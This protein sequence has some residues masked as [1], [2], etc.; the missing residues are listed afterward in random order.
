M[1]TWPVEWRVPV[2]HDM[3]P[4]TVVC[5]RHT[6]L[7]AMYR[8]FLIEAS[9]SPPLCFLD[10]AKERTAEIVRLVSMLAVR[11]AYVITMQ[12]A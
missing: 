10:G 2:N 12:H 8:P 9:V 3:P 4:L 1:L 6:S 5:I 11:K 7:V